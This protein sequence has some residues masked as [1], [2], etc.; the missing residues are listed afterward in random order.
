MAV[1]RLKIEPLR[2]PFRIAHPARCSSL[3]SA[4][5]SA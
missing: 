5:C 2:A 1:I 4:A 3:K